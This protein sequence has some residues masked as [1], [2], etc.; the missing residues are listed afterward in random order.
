MIAPPFPDN[1][2][3]RMQ[4]LHSYLVLDTAEEQA[5]D[6]MVKLAAGICGTTI[7]AI[8]LIDGSRQWFKAKLGMKDKESSRYTSFCGHTIFSEDVMEVRDAL[9]D[10]RFHD[11]PDVQGGC[12]IRFYAGAPLRTSGGYNLG[13]LCVFDTKARVLSEVQK[14]A[15]KVL[16]K[17]VVRQLDL[18]LKERQLMGRTNELNGIF[19]ISKIKEKTELSMQEMLQEIANIIPQAF[20]FPEY[21]AVRIKLYDYT[22][23][24]A[25]FKETPLRLISQI[26]TETDTLGAVEVHVNKKVA[27]DRTAFLPE[28]KNLMEVIALQ[29]KAVAETK[30]FELG[31]L[32]LNEEL[33]Q[34]VK[35]RASQLMESNR[36]LQVLNKELESFS[37][38]VSHDLRAPLRSIIGYS[39]ILNN[40][41][42]ENLGEEGMGILNN[43][44]KSTSKMGMLIDDLLAFSRL[45]R[46]EKVEQEFSMDLLVKDVVNELKMLNEDRDI[47]FNIESLPNALGDHSLIRHV[48]ANI[49]SNAV[50]FTA[51]REQAV[52]SV[53]SFTKEAE[54]VYKIEDNGVGFKLKYA[55]KIFEVFQRL[56][57]EAEFPGTG[58][59]MALAQKII[60][61]HGG[62]IWTEGELDKGASFYFTL[63][64]NENIE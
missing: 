54:I 21:T 31:I 5:Y 47:I 60:H 24:T 53:S 38:S 3:E 34:G 11:N 20:Q 6:E 61:R 28:E 36:K 7:S 44:I 62:R 19:A 48:V 1:E 15:L 59:G 46:Q 22:I 13:T 25:D 30:A 35:D 51:T 56:H 16:A 57:S 45:G 42:A 14:T 29:I 52:I 10:E 12:G 63:R 26:K 55:K 40:D 27:K 33:E 64:K 8:S 23:Q 58:I 43:I 2:N 39:K 32:N 17:Q 18:R 9:K 37:Y 50:K 4:A 41:F 49:L